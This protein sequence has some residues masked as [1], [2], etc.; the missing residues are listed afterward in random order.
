MK[1][2][3]VATMRIGNLM[4]SIEDKIDGLISD[5]GSVMSEISTA[6]VEFDVNANEMQ[7]ILARL[8]EAQSTVITAR[9]KSI[10]AH[11]DLKKWAEPKADFP[12]YCP[13]DSTKGEAEEPVR[14][15][16]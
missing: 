14:L 13:P 10:G 5:L 4:H 15:V 9:M 3:S 8:S 12:I 16:G 6:R 2:K 7:R 1:T 11:S